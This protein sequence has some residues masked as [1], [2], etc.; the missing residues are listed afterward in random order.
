MTK[1]LSVDRVVKVS[2]NLAPLAAAR[3]NF[4]ALLLLGSSEV[5]DQGERIRAYAGIDAVAAD[6]G[7]AAPEY[8]AAELFFSQSPRPSLLYVGRWI[9]EDA[10]AVLKGAA[11]SETEAALSAWTGITEGAMTIN[12]NGQ[13]RTVEDLDFSD[14]VTLEGIAAIASTALS[15]EGARLDYDGSR[16]ILSSAATGAAAVLGYADGPLASQ[17]KLTT[18]TALAPVPGADAETPLEAVAVL[19]DRSGDWYGL[20]FADPGLA[21]EDHLAVA[22]FI[23]ASAKSRIYAVTTTDTRVLDAAFGN[24]VASRLSGLGRRR[25]LV[26][27]SSNPHA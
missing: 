5:I 15:G 16:F 18:D 21:V 12:I 10:S 20:A 17:M 8:Q 3:R 11:L 7:L 4:G 14:A 19:A 13:Q 22:G 25:S 26:V 23:E 9:K 24:D 6:F 27:Y 1:A 2:I